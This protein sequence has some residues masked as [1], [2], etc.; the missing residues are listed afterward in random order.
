MRKSL[1]CVNNNWHKYV[2]RARMRKGEDGSQKGKASTASAELL[3][4]NVTANAEQ[5]RGNYVSQVVIILNDPHVRAVQVRKCLACLN[6]ESC[7]ICLMDA[8]QV[9]DENAYSLLLAILSLT[10][11]HC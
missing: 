7:K 3:L 6:L 8:S 11:E 4:L 9:C 1:L 10:S 5:H 2:I